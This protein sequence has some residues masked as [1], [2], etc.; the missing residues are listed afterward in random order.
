MKTALTLL[1]ASMVTGCATMRDVLPTTEYVL[2]AGMKISAETPNGHVE[3][4]AGNGTERSFSG[5]GWSKKR[6]LVPRSTRWYGSLGLYDPAASHS[7]YGR[8]LADEGR[9]FFESESEALRYLYV[10]SGHLKPVFSSRG[11]VVGFHVAPGPD[12][13]P[14]RHI[15][16]WQIYIH[17]ERPRALRGADDA[18]I[19]VEGG[20]IPEI[21]SPNPARIGHPMTLGAHEYAPEKG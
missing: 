18:A 10:G 16:L 17:G 5:D 12:G 14:T 13:E 6:V 1:L 19:K 7:P 9:L 15:V 11:L 20:E 3:I 4:R 8:L 21:A 2:S